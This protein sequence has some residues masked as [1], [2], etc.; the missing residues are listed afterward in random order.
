MPP[1]YLLFII[2]IVV[3]VTAYYCHGSWEE[4]NIW[5]TIVSLKTN[6]PSPSFGQ[7][8]CFSMQFDGS[9]EK[10][11]VTGKAIK[12]QVSEQELWL[13]KLD[14]VC[15][16]G[17]IEDERSYTLISQGIL[18]NKRASIVFYF[19]HFISSL[20]VI[21]CHVIT[22]YVITCY[23]CRCHTAYNRCNHLIFIIAGVCEDMEK[24]YSSLAPLFS[25]SIILFVAIMGN[26][27]VIFLLR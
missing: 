8:F 27:V 21:T 18:M 24:A 16:R 7:T 23:V 9:T 26:C 4:K 6:Q 22:C 15:S 20:Y 11:S 14:R 17:Q 10:T 12:T 2:F 25:K 5:Y 1:I 19:Y 13:T 3:A